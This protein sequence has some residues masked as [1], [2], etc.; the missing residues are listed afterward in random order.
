M[1]LSRAQEPLL[2]DAREAARMMGISTRTLWTLANMRT[3]PSIRIGRARRY[4]L[5]DLR[6]YIDAQR[7]KNPTSPVSQRRG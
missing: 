4:S 1:T 2:V 7:S 3:I 5:D 6:E